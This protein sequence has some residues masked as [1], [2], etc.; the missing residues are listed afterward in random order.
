MLT[1]YMCIKLV[2]IQLNSLYKGV[3]NRV[4]VQGTS[5][6]ISEWHECYKYI[7]ISV[8]IAIGLADQQLLDQ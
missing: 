8:A 1:V 4:I 5:N 6:G 7:G 2:Y 3:V